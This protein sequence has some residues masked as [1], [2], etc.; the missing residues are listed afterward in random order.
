MLLEPLEDEWIGQRR[1]CSG[2]GWRGGLRAHVV[3][4]PPGAGIELAVRASIIHGQTEPSSAG[5]C[6]NRH[7]LRRPAPTLAGHGGQKPCAYGLGFHGVREVDGG[8]G[9][10]NGPDVN[11][12]PE[13]QR[14]EPSGLRSE[15]VPSR[16]RSGTGSPS[17]TPASEVA[18]VAAQ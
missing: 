7:H 5:R 2:Q 12:E 18:P 11:G 15:E 10:W 4:R 6:R 8:F 3:D 17:G 1:A 9:L 14:R 13:C 16:H